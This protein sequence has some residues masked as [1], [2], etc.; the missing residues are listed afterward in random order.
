MDIVVK[1]LS[2]QY[3]AALIKR[4][5]SQDNQLTDHTISRTL[6]LIFRIKVSIEHP[7]VRNYFEDINRL[8]KV[9]LHH[10]SEMQEDQLVVKLREFEEDILE[11][12]L[13]DLKI[14]LRHYREMLNQVLQQVDYPTISTI[15]PKFLSL[16]IQE[17]INKTSK[18]NLNISY[19]DFKIELTKVM[20][21]MS[22]DFNHFTNQV[23][24]QCI[25]GNVLANDYEITVNFNQVEVFLTLFFGSRHNYKFYGKVNKFTQSTGLRPDR[26][27][28]TPLIL[29]LTK[30]RVA[31][32]G[33]KKTLPISPM[34][35]TYRGLE[36]GKADPEKD[37]EQPD[38]DLYTFRNDGIVVFGK[39]SQ[40]D[41]R[42]PDDDPEAEN[43]AMIMYNLA[44]NYY[45]IDCSKK[46]PCC[47]KLFDNTDDEGI[48]T[49]P[50]INQG[51][52]YSFAKTMNFS[53]REISF[54]DEQENK[55]NI[56]TDTIYYNYD[57][58]IVHSKIKLIC[59]SKPYEGQ[60]FTLKT[61]VYK[62]ENELKAI[63]TIGSGG[64]PQFPPDIFIPKDKGIS[65]VH[66]QLIFNPDT[67]TWSIADRS[68]TNGTFRIIKNEDQYSNRKPSEL[69]KLFNAGYDLNGRMALLTVCNYAFFITKLDE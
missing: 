48:T 49:S 68:S 25:C 9:A 56:G 11:Y 63:H 47:F 36:K 33:N 66:A 44:D 60:E 53:V 35:V 29:N 45:I 8:I 22:I 57:E 23:A 27:F 10:V 67:K 61:E 42:L 31:Y 1:D 64:D 28:T 19:L 16:H 40:C 15:L 43:V 20:N 4:K 58:N 34:N 52:L 17:N 54:D 51:Y 18:N 14:P 26:H 62:K 21:L 37:E 7:T 5:K 46:N 30:P 13:T 6:D 65:R 24:K 3:K 2:K 38:V 39:H 69:C 50:I 41:V 55:G 12:L 32:K 59:F